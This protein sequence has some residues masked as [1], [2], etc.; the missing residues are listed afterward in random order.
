MQL[1]FGILPFHT[2]LSKSVTAP[3]FLQFSSTEGEKFI[4]EWTNK[5]EGIGKFFEKN[6]WED[7][8]S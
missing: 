1:V 7:A 6:K 8:Y 2:N 5:S 4:S 3:T